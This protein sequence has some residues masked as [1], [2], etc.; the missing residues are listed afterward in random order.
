MTEQ[1]AAF[2]LR[3]LQVTAFD[4]CDDLW[5]RTD[6]EYA[7]VRF[8]VTCNDVF[9][10]GCS[11]AVDV[12]PENVELLEQAY[13]EAEAVGAQFYGSWLF[14]ARV[15]QMRPQGAAYPKQ[16]SP[17]WPL[18]DACGPPRAVDFGNPKAR[19]SEGASD[20]RE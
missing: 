16:A 15:R 12:T 3:V 10:W 20:E 14:C 2:V 5:W 9:F 11:D 4:Y 19:P 6:G 1:E 8:F 18:F 7:P 13:R 17:I